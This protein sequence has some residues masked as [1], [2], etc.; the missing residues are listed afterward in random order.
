M[1]FSLPT[2]RG[3]E[4]EFFISINYVDKSFPSEQHLIENILGLSGMLFIMPLSCCLDFAKYIINPNKA[5]LS[6]EYK[7]E[8][9][10]ERSTMSNLPPYFGG[11]N[12]V[13][14]TAPERAAVVVTQAPAAQGLAQPGRSAAPPITRLPI[15][16]DQQQPQPRR[17]VQLSDLHVLR[18]EPNG[19]VSTICSCCS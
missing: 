17:P 12:R 18:T 15:G 8:T 13:A 14:P 6:R 11:P 2:M 10:S 1:F 5:A 7:T 9:L 19:P 3:F 16:A 4:V